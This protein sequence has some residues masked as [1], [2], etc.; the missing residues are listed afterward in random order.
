MSIDELDS[1]KKILVRAGH[2]DALERAKQAI[3]ADLRNTDCYNSRVKAKMDNANLVQCLDS[4][5]KVL[6]AA[7]TPIPATRDDM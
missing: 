6:E 2:A 1:N 7:A 5:R 4:M 3:W